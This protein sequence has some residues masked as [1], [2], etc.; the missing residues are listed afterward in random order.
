MYDTVELTIIE[1]YGSPRTQK[2]HV[3]QVL[4]RWGLWLS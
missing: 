4:R 3:Y 2:L 1:L